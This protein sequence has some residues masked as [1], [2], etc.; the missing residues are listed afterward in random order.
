M[1]I[2][3]F[4]MSY[5]LYFNYLRDREVSLETLKQTAFHIK[6]HISDI[7]KDL[8]PIGQALINKAIEKVYELNER[9]KREI[10]RDN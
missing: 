9:D 1:F 4:G 7:S 3:L 8:E 10:N 6:S 5:I 2:V